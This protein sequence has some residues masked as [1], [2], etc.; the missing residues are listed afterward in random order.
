M[1]GWRT[2]AVAAALFSAWPVD[3]PAQAVITLP[4][5]VG[6][7]ESEARARLKEA[8]VAGSITVEKIGS[9]KCDR[10]GMTSG[11]VCTQSP[12]AGRRQ[13]VTMEVWLAVQSGEQTELMPP[14]VGLSESLARR[15]LTERGFVGPVTVRTT[16]ADDRC[17]RNTHQQIGT[18]CGLEPPSGA[19]VPL[20]AAITLLIQGARS[21]EDE[22]DYPPAVV[23]KTRQQAVD[24]LSKHN[25]KWVELRFVDATANCAAGTV[26]ATNARP[27]GLF[28]RRPGVRIE[29]KIA[30]AQP[31]P[32]E[33]FGCIRMIDV[34]TLPP[35][36]ALTRLDLLGYRGLIV[37]GE[38]ELIKKCDE[39]RPDPG[40]GKVCGQTYPAGEELC[41]GAKLGLFVVEQPVER[42]SGRG[43][44]HQQ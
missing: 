7:S 32:R 27:D 11:V 25:Y 2:A 41:S 42:D 9:E 4:D 22:T 20:S 30:G 16:G 33:R 12:A 35:E 40:R 5:V 6:L 34:T 10:K 28:P 8:G 1:R 3:S 29:L 15:R 19:R 38:S 39:K 36:E 14:L 17:E 18:V 37:I 31:A 43:L 13:L 26:C 44:P 23:G 21:Q 24:T